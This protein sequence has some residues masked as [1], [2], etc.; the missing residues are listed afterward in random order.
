MEPNP[1]SLFGLRPLLPSSGTHKGTR[2]CEAVGCR[3]STREG[4]PYCSNHIEKA[5]YI[6]G[7]LGKLDQRA[8][9]EAI[10]E[11]GRRH[12]PQD[13]F[14]VK[15]AVLLLR[16]KDF[17]IKSFSRRLDISH[18]AAAR[19][20]DLLVKW[21]HAKQVKTARGGKTISG[22]AHKDLVDGI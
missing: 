5:P 6:V 16:T 4:K 8:Q 2:D 15:E 3:K 12:I 14:F 11:K 1:P 20:V 13:G 22:L 10:L 18:K 9:E 7:I 19:L 21:G 17:T